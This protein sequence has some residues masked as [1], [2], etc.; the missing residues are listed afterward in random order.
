MTINGFKNDYA[1]ILRKHTKSA[2][3]VSMAGADGGVHEVTRSVK[4]ISFK[5]LVSGSE[6]VRVTDDTLG[7]ENLRRAGSNPLGQNQ[8]MEMG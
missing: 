4:T 6:G 2:T 8:F 5:S 3:T 1:Y 7:W